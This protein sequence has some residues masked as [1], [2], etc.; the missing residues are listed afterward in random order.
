M[1]TTG[2]LSSIRVI[3]LIKSR[4]L[5]LLHDMCCGKTVRDESLTKHACS[6][7][8]GGKLTVSQTR[9]STCLSHKLVLQRVC[10]TNTNLNVSVSQTQTRVS[11]TNSLALLLTTTPYHMVGYFT[12]C[13]LHCWQLHHIIWLV[14]LSCLLHFWQLHHTIWLVVPPFACFTVDNYTISYG[15]LFLSC[16]LHNW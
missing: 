2:H 12:F 4:I 15:W 13:L 10:L 3:K 7:I 14:V 16:L 11:H 8:E 6:V 9:T 1:S 5:H